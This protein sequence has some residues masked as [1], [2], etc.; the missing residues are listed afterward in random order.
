MALTSLQDSTL[1]SLIHRL[2]L[3]NLT[4]PLFD[5][6]RQLE[7]IGDAYICATNLRDDQREARALI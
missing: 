3:I 2:T 6:N 5:T 4:N 1:N 7:T